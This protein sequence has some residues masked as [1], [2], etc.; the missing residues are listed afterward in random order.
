MLEWVHPDD[1]ATVTEAFAQLTGG[2]ASEV[3]ARE[4]RVVRPDGDIRWVATRGVPVHDERGRVVEIAGYTVDV[5]A[6]RATA[7]ALRESEE[8]L[9]RMNETMDEVF[10]LVSAD[11]SRLHYVNPAF[12]RVFGIPSAALYEDPRCF[13]AAVHPEDAQLI[14]R[15]VDAQ[16]RGAVTDARIE[17][18]IIRPDG[19][20]RWISAQTYPITEPDGGVR[21]V[22]G[23]LSDVTERK[24]AEQALRERTAELERLLREKDVLLAEVHHRVKNNLQRIS[25]LMHM[26]AAKAHERP[27]RET[28]EE[29]E[30]RIQAMA[31]VHETLYRSSNLGAV[32]MQTYLDRIAQ[33]QLGAVEAARRA[34][35]VDVRA[36]GVTLD[37]DGALRCGLIVSELA[38]NALKHAFG[39]R[40]RGRIEVTLHAADGQLVLRVSDDGGR[41][42]AEVDFASEAT[43]GLRLVNGIAEQL[44]GAARRVPGP[45]SAIEIAFPASE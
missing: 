2:T 1:R 16:L 32:D 23:L 7:R 27:I 36:P 18:R 39:R 44:G 19:S 3:V 40:R 20:I 8:R 30:R 24:V 33:A 42:P 13:L 37:L 38:S 41:L 45:T 25:G 10:F 9:R 21:Q 5:T 4:Y 12:E 29:L 34:I 43:L 28:V 35:E 22:T 14:T 17:Y 26:M 15:V 31:L 11:R 6:S